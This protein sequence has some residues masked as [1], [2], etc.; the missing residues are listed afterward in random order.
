MMMVDSKLMNSGKIYGLLCRDIIYEEYDKHSCRHIWGAGFER[1]RARFFQGLKESDGGYWSDDI[2]GYRKEMCDA[3][4][5]F[6]S[7]S[8]WEDVLDLCFYRIC[9]GFIV[10]RSCPMFDIKVRNIY[11]SFSFYPR[12]L[13][14]LFFIKW[15]ERNMFHV[16]DRYV[17]LM[18]SDRAFS[19]A[20]EETLNDED[21]EARINYSFSISLTAERFINF[22]GLIMPCAK[23]AEFYRDEMTELCR[24]LCDDFKAYKEKS[25][26]FRYK[27]NKISVKDSIII[28]TD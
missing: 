26:W 10:Y 11:D 14:E 21:V 16:D 28:N 20:K 24:K 9:R 25:K 12:L 17:G 4:Y 13:L 1:Q 5:E 8:E 2:Y 15:L 27:L 22:D 23:N 7:R 18:I 19:L 3:L 6:V